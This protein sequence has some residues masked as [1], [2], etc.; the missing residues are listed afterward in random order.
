MLDNDTILL[1]HNFTNITSANAF[2]LLLM[3]A[4]GQIVTI[5]PVGSLEQIMNIDFL[6]SEMPSDAPAKQ[7]GRVVCIH[8]DF[9]GTAVIHHAIYEADGVY[10]DMRL[11]K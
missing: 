6:S 8:I 2:L 4:K 3:I 7:F 11:I 1:Y 5:L 10:D 9:R